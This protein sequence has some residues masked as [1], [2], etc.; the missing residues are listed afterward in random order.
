MIAN[1]FN[2]KRFFTKRSD[3]VGV[4]IC[5]VR[6]ETDAIAAIESGADALGFNLYP[7][8]KR[9]LQ[10][11]KE[12]VWIRELPAEISRIAL[13][14]NSTLEEAT[15]LLDIELFDGLQLHGEESE[16]YLPIIGE[17]PIN[18]YSKP[19][20]WKRSSSWSGFALTLSL[21]F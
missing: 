17:V 13:V 19:F 11:Q 9:Y 14:V 2:L 5:G 16:E 15:Q 3:H 1:S 21:A 20:G 10:W 18:R 4:K 6:N 8:S 7:G 12:A